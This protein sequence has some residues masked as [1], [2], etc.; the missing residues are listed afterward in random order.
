MILIIYGNNAICN[1]VWMW[2]RNFPVITNE[3]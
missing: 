1:S 3:G 2:S